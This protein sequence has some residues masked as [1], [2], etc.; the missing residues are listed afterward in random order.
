MS[1]KEEIE[2]KIKEQRIV[3]A[4]KKGLVGFSGKIGTIVKILGSEI[5]YQ[6]FDHEVFENQNKD[7]KNSSELMSSIPTM[8]MD[9]V[10]RP[11]GEEW[12]EIG[13]TY[14]SYTRKI[15]LY[16]D[17]LSRGMHMEIKYYEET[18][19]LSLTYKGY[20]AYREVMGEIETYI[21]D[22]QWENWVESLFRLSKKIQRERKEIEFKNKTL[23]SQKIKENWINNLIKKW[24]NI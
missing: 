3:E 17:G 16:F 22:T 19:E 12:G 23:I 6:S 14:F 10:L 11:E 13:E 20:L 1:K 8:E 5:T 2:L 15:G 21:P 9:E 18:S 24:G 4:N 7:P